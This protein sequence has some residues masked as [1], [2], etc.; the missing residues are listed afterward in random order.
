MPVA[1]LSIDPCR[2]Y[3]S[4][5]SCRATRGYYAS[6]PKKEDRHANHKGWDGII[7]KTINVLP[8]Y[9]IADS[10]V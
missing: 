7:A 4:P 8:M 3:F 1:S 10:Q 9:L 6:R 5:P 2:E